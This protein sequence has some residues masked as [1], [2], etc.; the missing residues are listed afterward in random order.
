[1]TP[2]ELEQLKARATRPRRTV[3]L[4][5]DGELRG[6]IEAVEQRIED[7]ESAAR[8]DNDL[9]LGSKR[10]VVDTSAEAAELEELHRQAESAT[11]HVVVEGL[12]GTPWRTLLAAHPPKPDDALDKAFDANMDTV[13]IPMVRAC[14]I[15][16][17]ST[18]DGPIHTVDLDWLVGDEQTPGFLTDLQ[19]DKLVDAA[20]ATSRGDDAVPLRRTP[21]TTPSSVEG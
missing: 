6:R 11:L 8:P 20:I 5:L 16:H 10:R 17:R 3:R 18:S 2:E 15:G 21:S 14:V 12:P 13:R 9:R 1:M 4:V 7:A 19:M